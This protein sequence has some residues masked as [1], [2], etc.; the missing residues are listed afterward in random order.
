MPRR[1]KN[2]KKSKTKIGE[3]WRKDIKLPNVPQIQK[4]K[5]NQKDVNRALD[6]LSVTVGPNEYKKQMNVRG[7]AN[8]HGELEHLIKLQGGRKLL[9]K[10]KDDQKSILDKFEKWMI[11]HDDST[12]CGEDWE[13]AFTKFGR[14]AVARRTF[15]QDE[16]ILQI[17]SKLF[18][19][20]RAAWGDEKFSQL[21]RND[22][23]LTN[24]HSLV[25]IAYLLLESINP[26]SFF[27]EYID[28]LPRDELCLP[29]F[30]ATPEE[31]LLLE[32][33]DVGTII[34][35][36]LVNHAQHYIYLRT[37]FLKNDVYGHLRWYDY[38][39]AASMV[40]TRQSKINDFI[41]LVPGHDFV[42]GNQV[43]N[44]S[45]FFLQET[46]D[47]GEYLV[48]QAGEEFKQGDEILMDYGHRSSEDMLS[49][50][51]F[52]V[53]KNP[54]DTYKFRLALDEQDEMFKFKKIQLIN[55]GII[56]KNA[57]YVEI[58]LP[59]N[60]KDLPWK[61]LEF[62]RIQALIKDEARAYL[63]RTLNKSGTKSIN[64]EN[65]KRA[66]ELLRTFFANEMRGL[67][68][69]LDQNFEQ[70]TPMITCLIA[71]I[72][73]QQYLVQGILSKLTNLKTSECDDLKDKDEA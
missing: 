38:A 57:N 37:L 64:E 22:S 50:N 35:K 32:G 26:N 59:A 69:I 55:K 17:P 53:D 19:S 34:S 46:V 27:R 20:S 2:K 31:L 5:V 9:W 70:P 29:S 71:F 8:V 14:G 16:K 72:Q 39:W 68:D 15:A 63:Q 41:T 1:K 3:L 21:F 67:E 58:H 62:A 18:F 54:Y 42:N 44:C 40:M 49:S 24:N 60:N 65:E 30:A 61:L 4:I 11:S 73:T 10:P 28:A 33:F 66:K 48:L 47:S 13:I 25:V 7:F 52:V 36:L 45:S 51:G 43:G 12:G 6:K 23:I 56:E